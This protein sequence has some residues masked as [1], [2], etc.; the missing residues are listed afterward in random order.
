MSKR[1]L[2]W[3]GLGI[4]LVLLVVGA[5][6]WIPTPTPIVHHGMDRSEV[7]AIVGP[8]RATT[9][10]VE[11]VSF[12]G[13]CHVYS[14]QGTWLLVRY[15]KAEKIEDFHF[16]PNPTAWDGLRAWLRRLGLGA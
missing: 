4:A 11:G 16:L 14:Y 1:R 7:E 5:A 9:D 8:H 10:H 13:P 15:D 3:C 6:L 12:S 2:R